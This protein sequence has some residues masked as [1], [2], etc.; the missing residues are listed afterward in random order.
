MKRSSLWIVVL[1]LVGL[2]T[3]CGSAPPEGGGGD[4]PPVSAADEAV[5]RLAPALDAIVPEDTAIEK[6]AGDFQF[7]E[8]PVW[9]E[10]SDGGPMLL[11]SDIPANTIR[12]WSPTDGVS[13]YL[14]PVMAEDSTAGGTGGSNGLTLDLEGRLVL[15]EH[16]N[17]QVSRIEADGSRTVL[18]DRFEGKRLNSPNDIVYH[19]SGWAYFTD[20]PYGLAGQDEDPNKELDVNGIYRL[21]PEGQLE[22]VAEQTRPN[23]IGLSPDETTLYVANSDREQLVWFA[24]DVLEDGALSEGRIFFDASGT[25]EDGAP[26]G[27]R[28]DT[29][30]NL[31]ATGPGGV[32]ILAPD[33]TH[34]G[35]IR[36]PEI[37]ANVGWGDEDGKTLYM[38]ARTGLYRIRLL[39]EGKRP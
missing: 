2:E 15:C 19:S 36:P 9:I 5:L 31:Y 11:F 3:G 1:A 8:G 39:A 12:A 20:P 28:L 22:L 14:H 13:E 35:T 30:G 26:D 38:T 24:Y 16:G 32:W 6:V 25:D 7:V 4:Q 21:G 33:G 34:L 18:A 23:G 10:E 29:E 27:L 37:P 17:R